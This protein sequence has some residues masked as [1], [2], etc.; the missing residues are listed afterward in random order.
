MRVNLRDDDGIGLTEVLV[1]MLLLALL[2]IVILPTLITGM[3]LA[4]TNTTIAAATQ[5]A[6]DRIS[7]AQSAGT[8]CSAVVDAV[9]GTVETTDKRGI[10]LRATT[11]VVG[12]CPAVGTAETLTVSTTVVRV[13]SGAQLASASTLVLVVN[14]P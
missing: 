6:N 2:A 8:E 1:A 3:K 13:D 5:L 4:Q 14:A 11:T 12:T 10:L 7:I 9:D